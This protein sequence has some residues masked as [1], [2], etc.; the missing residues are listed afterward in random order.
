MT[1]LNLRNAVLGM[2][3]IFIFVSSTLVFGYVLA[4]DSTKL[5]NKT[6]KKL[7]DEVERLAKQAYECR[8]NNEM[9]KA[10]RIFKKAL[11]L[12]KPFANS[13]TPRK[14]LGHSSAEFFIV[15]SL[16]SMFERQGRFTD[17]EHLY[18][19]KIRK[20]YNSQYVDEQVAELLMKQGKYDEARS[21]LR[22]FVPQMEM[23]K[24]IGCGHPIMHYTDLKNLLQCCEEKT[25]SL[26]DTELDE[27]LERRKTKWA[28]LKLNPD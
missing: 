17:A 8:V 25:P 21:I 7:E 5:N 9:E 4:K 2:L 28:E 26:T 14:C 6:S 18:E 24:S 22:T 23:P 27:I 1:S 3:L 15:G 12:N 19:T 11:R 10:E 13:P 16:V 20:S